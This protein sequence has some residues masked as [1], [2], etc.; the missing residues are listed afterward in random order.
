MTAEVSV[1]LLAKHDRP[2]T[3]FDLEAGRPFRKASAFD[4]WSALA[5]LA[6]ICFCGALFFHLRYIAPGPQPGKGHLRQCNN[7]ALTLPAQL[8]VQLPVPSSPSSAGGASTCPFKL[9][10]ARS[11]PHKS[12]AEAIEA[13]FCSAHPE[14][15]QCQRQHFVISGYSK[16]PSHI[17]KF[18]RDDLHLKYTYYAHADANKNGADF[19]APNKGDEAHGFV[20]FI[21]EHYD[22]LPVTVVFLHDDAWPHHNPETPTMIRC[23]LSYADLPFTSFVTGMFMVKDFAH[24]W[25]NEWTQLFSAAAP[26]TLVVPSIAVNSRFAFYCCANFAVGRNAIL[27]QPLTFWYTIATLRVAMFKTTLRSLTSD[28]SFG[29]SCA[30]NTHTLTSRVCLVRRHILTRMNVFQPL[31]GRNAG[32]PNFGAVM[33]H[34][35]HHIFGMPWSL[36]PVSP[37][38]MCWHF[39]CRS[40]KNSA[41]PFSIIAPLTHTYESDAT[42]QPPKDWRGYI[43]QTTTVQKVQ[44]DADHVA[45][46]LSPPSQCDLLADEFYVSVQNNSDP[47]I[48]QSLYEGCTGM[49]MVPDFVDQRQVSEKPPLR[50]LLV[51][52]DSRPLVDESRGSPPP[53]VFLP[54]GFWNQRLPFWTMASAL[55]YLYAKRHGYDYVQVELPQTCSYENRVSLGANWCKIWGLKEVRRLHP[56]YDWYLY[57]DS[58]CMY[59]NERMA[60]PEALETLVKLNP[61]VANATVIVS[62]EE[63]TGCYIHLKNR[64]TKEKECR[65]NSG[66]MLWKNTP[67]MADMLDFWWRQGEEGDPYFRKE[68]PYEQAILGSTVYDRFPGAVAVVPQEKMFIN[69]P[70]GAYIA[71]FWTGMDGVVKRAPSNIDRIVSKLKTKDLCGESSECVEATRQ[72]QWLWPSGEGDPEQNVVRFLATILPSIPLLSGAPLTPKVY[73]RHLFL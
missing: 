54:T 29:Q 11:G 10:R 45:A 57:T 23:L 4:C 55:H 15:M 64:P 56:G 68:W 34:S 58:D 24:E 65:V 19:L 35:W 7:T 66:I 72:G 8:P 41:C 26:N 59:T 20:K 67:V 37:K 60:W 69:T 18:V 63:V 46:L 43:W 38:T 71:H 52:A 3:S 47:C 51:Q 36:T 49:A 40:E 5:A 2:H 21:V 27:K 17:Q 25:I 14:A 30:K 22:S 6:F 48:D 70:S 28:L 53:G 13:S 62:S 31:E 16:D 39:E 42:S 50:V 1:G 33:E 9:K 12:Q 61:N 44:S 32:R 73:A